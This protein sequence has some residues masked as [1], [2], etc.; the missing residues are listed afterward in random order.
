M[1]I[2]MASPYNKKPSYAKATEGKEK[3]QILMEMAFKYHIVNNY[4]ALAFWRAAVIAS[5]SLSIW[6]NP[7]LSLPIM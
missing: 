6:K 4:I 1:K 7:A 2:G 5:N 3:G